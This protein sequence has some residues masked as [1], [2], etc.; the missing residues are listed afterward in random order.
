[1]TPTR[2]LGSIVVGA[3]IALTLTACN[4]YEK[5]ETPEVTSSTAAAEPAPVESDA[6][7]VE[8]APVVEAPAAEPAVEEPAVE[9]PAA[10]ADDPQFGSCKEAI[11]AGYGNYTSGVDP[12]YA[13]YQDRDGDGLVCES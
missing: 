6:A 3:L 2:K 11:A 8:P 9:A 4:G 7:P 1:M 5:A 12:E 13:W 10:P